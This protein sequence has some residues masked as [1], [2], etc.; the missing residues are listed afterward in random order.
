MGSYRVIRRQ[1]SSYLYFGK[2]D[3]SGTRKDSWGSG[4]LFL[5]IVVKRCSPGCKAVS[6]FT[7]LSLSVARDCWTCEDSK[8][9]SCDAIVSLLLQC[10]CR[11]ED[12]SSSDT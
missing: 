9:Y 6:V 7:V 3:T 5:L 12:P 2:W 8:A 11:T 1:F 10:E 4:R